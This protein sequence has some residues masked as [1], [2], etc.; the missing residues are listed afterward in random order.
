MP[1]A[2]LAFVVLPQ[3]PIQSDL[4]AEDGEE[5]GEEAVGEVV[6]PGGVDDER[7][8]DGERGDDEEEGDPEHQCAECP[9]EDT[10]LAAA[11][12]R[13]A[14]APRHVFSPFSPSWPRSLPASLCSSC[15]LLCP[16]PRWYSWRYLSVRPLSGPSCCSR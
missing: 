2:C 16:F 1:V 9:A 7:A 6:A 12:L 8:G 5:Q 10:F 13:Q 3:K 15:L 11:A 4:G 14:G